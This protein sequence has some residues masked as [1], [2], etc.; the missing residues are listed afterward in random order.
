[1]TG[2]SLIKLLVSN[3]LYYTGIVGPSKRQYRDKFL[4]LTYHRVLANH[5][6]EQPYF[7]D[8]M[9]ITPEA[10]EMQLKYLTRNANIRPLR[11]VLTRMENKEN[12]EPATVV[13]TFDD[14]Y[15][16]NY[17]IAFPL[18]KKYGVTA[19]IFLTTDPLDTGTPLPWDSLASKISFLWDSKGPQAFTN[20]PLRKYLSGIEKADKIRFSTYVVDEMN[21]LQRRERE[22]FWNEL[23]SW[24]ESESTP[25]PE[26][27]MM[28]WDMVK[29]MAAYGI[30]FENHTVHHKLVD[31]LRDEELEEEIR[32]GSHRIREVLQQPADVIAYPRGKTLSPSKDAYIR[33]HFRAAMSTVSG[34]NTH[35]TDKYELYRKDA[36][37]LLLQKKFFPAYFEADVCG[38]WDRIRHFKN[39]AQALSLKTLRGADDMLNTYGSAF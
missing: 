31:E 2:S 27:P 23:E 9:F 33:E 5:G 14:G 25:A 30:D 24:L 1:M 4:I 21:A 3:A 35:E 39:K 11:E 22:T 16:D 13:L 12:F 15:I 36:N 37:F 7:R 34:F 26:N 17:T 10:F 29:E 32:P 38:F 28:T 19:T 18:L 8:G 20:S 6:S